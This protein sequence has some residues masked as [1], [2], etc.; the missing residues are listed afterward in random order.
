MP[1][2]ESIKRRVCQ[3]FEHLHLY[4]QVVYL[5]LRST[6]SANI[7]LKEHTHTCRML[8]LKHVS[9]PIGIV[10]IIAAV[11]VQY[12]RY[13]Y[14]E[15]RHHRYEFYYLEHPTM[16]YFYIKYIFAYF[17]IW[18]IICRECYRFSKAKCNLLSRFLSNS[19]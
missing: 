19:K 8:V 18:E 15:L 1:I 13:T 5:S 3:Q 10:T 14:V 11:P 12:Y 6:I 7:L 16:L 9:V 17:L 4:L 2:N